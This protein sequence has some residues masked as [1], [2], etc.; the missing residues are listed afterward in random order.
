MSLFPA[1]DV[2]PSVF[3]KRLQ[4]ARQAITTF[5][6][7]YCGLVSDRA[8]CRCNHRLPAALR[9][10][11]V[12]PE[13]LDF[14]RDAVSFEEARALVRRVDDARWALEVHRTSR[15]RASDIDFA[16]RMAHMIDATPDRAA[17]DTHG[18]VG[19]RHE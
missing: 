18:T 9:L 7:A 10:G 8:S 2:A 15:P 6:R 1:L 14:T 11:R 16:R 5:T 13:S 4:R 3:R 12:R 17:S 19:N